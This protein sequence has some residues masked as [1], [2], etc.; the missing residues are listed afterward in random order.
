M[1][2]CINRAPR[3]IEKVPRTNGRKLRRIPASE[4]DISD[5]TNEIAHGP[6]LSGALRPDCVL[7]R[8]WEPQIQEYART[9]ARV[10]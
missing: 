9:R 4:M 10:F 3:Y 2:R 8:L 1:P 5:L 7:A 6:H